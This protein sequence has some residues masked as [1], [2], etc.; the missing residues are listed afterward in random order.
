MGLR[1]VVPVV[2]SPLNNLKISTSKSLQWFLFVVYI[3]LIFL[4]SEMPVFTNFGQISEGQLAGVPNVQ[5][6]VHYSGEYEFL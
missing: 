5:S 3:L 4:S 1:Y 6:S 2:S